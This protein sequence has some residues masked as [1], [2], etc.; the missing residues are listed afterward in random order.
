MHISL[1]SRFLHG[2]SH[3][4]LPFLLQSSEDTRATK[5]RYISFEAP[6]GIEGEREG[7]RR[8]RKKEENKRK[9]EKEKKKE[10]KRN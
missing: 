5:I 10:K 2:I 8:E 4:L 7:G 1:I 6:E 9:F 3:T